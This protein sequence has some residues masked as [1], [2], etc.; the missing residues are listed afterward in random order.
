[1]AINPALFP[2]QTPNQIF[3]NRLH[4]NDPEEDAAVTEYHRGIA[5]LSS[6]EYR[7]IQCKNPEAF[8]YA[9]KK[10]ARYYI[11]DIFTWEDTTQ[12]RQAR[13]YFSRQPPSDPMEK[14]RWEMIEIVAWREIAVLSFRIAEN[15]QFTQNFLLN[16][17]E[18]ERRREISERRWR[19]IKKGL[20]YTGIA[21]GVIV[22]IPFAIVA[23]IIIGIISATYDLFK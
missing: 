10:H 1:M 20:E 14:R 7:I 12:F 18:N 3:N 16:Q 15:Y 17:K 22:A 11:G 6:R 23:L 21:V 2:G 5:L 9:H 19:P 4:S 8:K 13:D